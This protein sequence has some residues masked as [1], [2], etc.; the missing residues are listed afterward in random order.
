MAVCSNVVILSAFKTYLFSG[1]SL[2]AW[3]GG[4]KKYIMSNCPRTGGS[5]LFLNFSQVFV[6]KCIITFLLPS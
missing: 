5:F 6:I 4:R 2:H 1:E 3:E